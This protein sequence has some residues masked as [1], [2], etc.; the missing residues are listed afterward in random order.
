MATEVGVWL[1][2]VSRCGYYDR[3]H[4]KRGMPPEYGALSETLASLSAWTA[5]RRLSETS[6]FSV[7]GLASTF[8]LTLKR[9]ENGDALLGLWNRIQTKSNKIASVGVNDIVGAVATQFTEIDE[10]RIPG[11]ATYFY[12][13]P[14]EGRIATVRV[15][16]S[17]NGLHSFQQYMHSFLR[18]IN[19]QH[20]A[21]APG[22]GDEIHVVGYRPDPGSDD[23]RNLRAQFRAGTIPRAG[24]AQYIIDNSAL[25][26]RAICK[27]TIS[28]TVQDQK[29]WWQ[30]GL[31]LFGL[32]A[33]RDRQDLQDDVVIKA[34]IP[35]SFEKDEV[36]AIVKDWS[37]RQDGG[38]EAED[39][40]GFIL[41]GEGGTPRWLSKSYARKTL[42]LEIEW[43]D[44]ELV[45]PESLLAQLQAR[46]AQILALGI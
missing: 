24:E 22:E 44:D 38:N 43:L 25:I 16:H 33:R 19:P 8:F 23:I 12:L 10:D 29:Q 3:T 6:T 7:D 5:G 39:D 20:V 13:M 32:G 4:A 14:S 28:N 21:T 42:D 35:M 17:M 36:E 27:T 2:T 1:F 26:Q 30:S 18:Y 40:I 46:R 15:K 37:E 34:E 31:R 9:A 41:R 45:N 11:F